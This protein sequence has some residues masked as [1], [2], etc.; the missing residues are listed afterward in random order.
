MLRPGF[1]PAQDPPGFDRPRFQLQLRARLLAFLA[2]R[3]AR[4]QANN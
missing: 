2:A 3:L 4:A 1:V